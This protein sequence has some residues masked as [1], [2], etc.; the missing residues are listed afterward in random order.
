MSSTAANLRV[1]T[2]AISQHAQH[3]PFPASEIRMNPFEVQRLDWS[4]IRGVPIVPDD[5]I[6]TGRFR[7]VC[8][9]ADHGQG[10]FVEQGEKVAA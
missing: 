10:L 9:N 1:I 5:R 7:I 6:G 3:C 2:E 8:A 4:E